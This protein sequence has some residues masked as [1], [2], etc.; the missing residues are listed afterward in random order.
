MFA[1]SVRE[2]WERKLR[3]DCAKVKAHGHP[4]DIFAFVVT[5][6][7]SA[8]ERDASIKQVKKRF[9]WALELFSLERLRTMLVAAPQLIAQHPQIL[10][11]MDF[12]WV[13]GGEERA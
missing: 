11:L 8:T 7:I 1:Y 5:A 12:L 13:T 10:D 3:D 6:R 4:C 2:D 9:G